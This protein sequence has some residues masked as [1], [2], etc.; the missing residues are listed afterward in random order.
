MTIYSK[1]SGRDIYK[2]YLLKPLK[3]YL[4]NSNHIYTPL[5]SAF[6]MYF[7]HSLYS[8]IYMKS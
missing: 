8:R 6:K 4:I 7:L 5:R 3:L 1:R 2:R